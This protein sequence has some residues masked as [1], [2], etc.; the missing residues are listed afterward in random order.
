[1]LTLQ[2]LAT[3]EQLRV[4]A[5]Y[6]ELIAQLA[7][8]GNTQQVLQGAGGGEGQSPG[9]CLVITWHTAL[10][11]FVPSVTKPTWQR[12]H[13]CQ[14]AGTGALPLHPNCAATS[15]GKA[16]KVSKGLPKTLEEPSCARPAS[17]A[18]PKSPSPAVRGLRRAV[19]TGCW[20]SRCGNRRRLW[21]LER[22]SLPGPLPRAE[23][24][25]AEQIPSPRSSASRTFP[26]PQAS[27]QARRCP[28]EFLMTDTL[29]TKQQQGKE[30][31]PLTFFLKGLLL[32]GNY[33]SHKMTA[34]CTII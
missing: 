6:L 34:N 26:L 14:D 19:E 5:G 22:P 33:R 24:Q 29:Q 28:T 8:S 13:R 27:R 9:I 17:S 18:F 16:C 2:S 20:E 32:E 31:I 1:M 3:P 15:K 7:E 11:V 25:G 30:E 12:G 10:R 4:P 21:R 23:L